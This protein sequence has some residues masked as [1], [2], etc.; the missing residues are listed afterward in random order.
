MPKRSQDSK[1][2]LYNIPPMVP[3]PD[4]VDSHRSGRR[5]R[6]QEIVPPVGGGGRIG[7]GGG[8][9]RGNVGGIGGIGELSGG[10][11]FLLAVLTVIALGG[12][13]AAY[14][15]YDQY[16]T[17]LRQTQLRLNDLERTLALT[18]EDAAEEAAE[19]MSKV[20]VTI[21]QY[22]LLWANWRN[23]NQTIDDIRSEIARNELANQ[24]NHQA[25]QQAITAMGGELGTLQGLQADMANMQQNVGGGSGGDQNLVER[26]ETLEQVVDTYRRQTNDSLFRLQ[27]HLEELQRLVLTD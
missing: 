24:Q 26:V 15:F 10:V 19:I 21:E 20:E 1:E 4:H 22:D 2:D 23:N 3:D 8:V 25:I 16:Q 6:G 12:S 27:E 7:G 5:A 18:G 14:Y 17:D 11:Q 9:G 13:A